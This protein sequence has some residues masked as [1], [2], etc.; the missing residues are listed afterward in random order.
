MSRSPA[1]Y[2]KQPEKHLSSFIQIHCKNQHDKHYHILILKPWLITLSKVRHCLWVISL[3]WLPSYMF[4]VILKSTTFI[5]VHQQRENLKIHNF[6]SK[7]LFSHRK[8]QQKKIKGLKKK[9]IIRTF[10][11]EFQQSLFLPGRSYW[12]LCIYI[13]V[14]KMN[15]SIYLP[16]YLRTYLPTHL[17]IYVFP[18]KYLGHRGHRSERWMT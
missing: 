16:T 10:S 14:Y 17:S 6:H 5:Y 8:N 3:S 15:L 4:H 9:M 13:S 1:H 18:L 11:F 7:G 12:F 2:Y